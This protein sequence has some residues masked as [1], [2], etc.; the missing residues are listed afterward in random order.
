MENSKAFWDK[1]FIGFGIVTIISGIYLIVQEDYLI[2][3]SGTMVG[4]WL[5]FLNSKQSKN[6]E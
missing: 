3:I 6:V 2:G 4:I 5:T 1:V